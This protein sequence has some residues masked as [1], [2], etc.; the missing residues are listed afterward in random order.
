MALLGRALQASD[1]SIIAMPSR[2]SLFRRLLSPILEL[3]DARSD[4]LREAACQTIAIA[5][6]F[7]A[8]D[9]S[10]NRLIVD[11]VCDSKKSRID[12]AYQRLVSAPLVKEVDHP[13]MAEAIL[14]DVKGT[15]FL[16]F[17]FLRFSGRPQRIRHS[18]SDGIP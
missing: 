12:H 6:R 3:M 15:Y 11:T 1:G 9:S 18:S 17:V 2:R 14:T 7:L 8:D 10:Y 13:P 4:G 16:W 5:R